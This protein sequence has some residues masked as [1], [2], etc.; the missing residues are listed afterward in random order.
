M[1]HAPLSIDADTPPDFVNEE[2]VKWWQ[3]TDHGHTATDGVPFLVERPT[4][5]QEY[6][7][8]ADGAVV[9]STGNL[10][11]LYTHLDMLMLART[12]A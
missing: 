11:V 5:E 10:E 3:L 12:M 6:V 8:V 1:S 4:G 7:I 2:G 9:Y